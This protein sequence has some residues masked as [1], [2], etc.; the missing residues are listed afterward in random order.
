[1]SRTGR[2]SIWVGGSFRNRL[3]ALID[4]RAIGVQTDQLNNS[5]QYT[6]LGSAILTTGLHDVELRY[7]SNVFA[8]GSGGSEYGLG[9]LI[10]TLGA[11][12]C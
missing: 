12:A 3:S 2:Y 6:S 1:V 11:S 7:S 10:L 9:P 5:A 4:G 8:P